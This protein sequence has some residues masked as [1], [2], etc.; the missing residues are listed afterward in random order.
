[1]PD[2]LIVKVHKAT[3]KIDSVYY[4]REKNISERKNIEQAQAQSIINCL[5]KNLEERNMT[6]RAGLT[7]VALLS[8]EEK[9]SLF[10]GEMPELYGFE[11]Y[12]GGIFVMPNSEHT[13]A[14]PVEASSSAFV[15]SWDWRDRHGRN[16]M[17]SVK[18]QGACASCWAFSAIGALE[19][20]VNLYYNR[21]LNLNLSE[22][23]LVSCASSNG[24]AGGSR[25][26][27]LNYIKNNGVVNEDCFLYTHTNV[28][29]NDKCN[30]PEEEIFL[31]DYGWLS[32]NEAAIKQKLFIAPVTFGISSWSHA[33][34]LAGYKTIQEGD[35]IYL[36]SSTETGWVTISST[37]HSNLI[38]KTVWLL[39]NSWGDTWGDNGYAYIYADLGNINTPY[40]LSGN[41]TSM[42][43][44]DSDVV[45]SDADGD[46]YYFWGLGPKPSFCPSW[47]PDVPDGND[48]NHNQGALDQYGF[49]EVLNPSSTS[50]LTV[51][52]NEIFTTRLSINRN[53]VIPSNATLSVNNILNMFGHV[54]ITVSNG[55]KLI[56]D[57]G[58]ITNAEILLSAGS[59]FELMNGGTVVLRTNTSF[60]APTGAI[61]DISHGRI[62]NSTDFSTF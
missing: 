49:L 16:W 50:A 54:T 24:C 30:S 33:L 22:Q 51:I 2:Q 12:T 60:S 8:Y 17:T 44:T 35:R 40:Y 48:A 45:C 15:D 58:L 38:G 18:I 26:T 37:N 19:A 28:D 1:M 39:K 4:T 36:R 6:W 62:I 20:Y 42:S 27:A 14:L 29:C 25:G 57:N 56:V 10:G 5:N 21:S 34:V 59:Q 47:V 43:Y 31:G 3:I 41:I 55:G 61:V 32:N 53:I 11:Y 7:P 52:G 46:G 23:Q 9:K 13:E